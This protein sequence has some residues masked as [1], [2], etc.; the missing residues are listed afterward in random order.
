MRNS[1]KRKNESESIK[2]TGNAN[3]EFLSITSVRV[4]YV[5]A[6]FFFIY[7]I[8]SLRVLDVALFNKSKVSASFLEEETIDSPIKHRADIIDRNGTL[9]AVNLSTASLFANPRLI[10]NIPDIIK[11]LNTI[12]P[13]LEKDKLREKLT[14]DKTFVWIK[15]NLTPE[16]QYKV[17]ALGT[18][19]LGF[20]QEE[21]RV[22]PHK[23]LLAHVLGMVNIDGDGISG[24][25]KQ[26]ERYLSGTND[27]GDPNEPLQ[28]SIDIRVQ[29][30]VHDALK[31]ATDE[32]KALG[33]T[34]IVMDVNSGEILAMVSL[35][36]FDLNNPSAATDEQKF[37]RMTSGVYEMGSTFKTFNMAM[38][39]DIGNMD[40]NNKYDVSE[41]IKIGGFSIKDYHQSKGLLTMPEI[42]MYSSNIGSAKIAI[43]VGGDK[44]KKFLEK[45]GLLDDV[46][47]ELPE[48][49][50][51]LFPSKWSKISSMTI[52]YGHGIAVT[53]IHVIKATAALING[54]ILNQATL[55][56]KDKFNSIKGEKVISPETSN[57]MR[58]LMRW[59][60]KYGTGTKADVAGYMVGGKTGSADK[61]SNTGGYN[62][63][64]NISSFIGVF[65]INA[66]QYAV[67]VML[68]AP[69][70]DASTGGFTTG[71]MVAA[72]VAN[73][74]IK[75]MAP[76][77]GVMPVDENDYNIR[78]EFWYDYEKPGE[79]A[80]TTDH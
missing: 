4:L 60:V 49:A 7:V 40:I 73:E 16:D 25:E 79:D 1:H 5:G 52:S 11:K 47:I 63:S 76:I 37:N 39:F 20:K 62:K 9:L 6:I 72:P 18:P 15:R 24:I 68:D 36:D 51:P 59:T 19:G 75:Y 43:D 32:F 55:L 26:F 30:L 12:F 56:K 65:P 64:S 46:E 70:G 34:A 53:P 10:S 38:G 67:M 71:G 42:Y 2:E 41:P 80:T 23:E 69:I 66:P 77:V 31:K 45:L 8:L 22:Y 57:K 28:L 44:Q 13:D 58:K 78:K 35:P 27:N 17:N 3:A 74:I 33:G 29:S 14:P 54:G 61:V 21:K 48:K 50:R